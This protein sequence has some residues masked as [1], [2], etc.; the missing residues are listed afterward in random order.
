MD[1][2]IAGVPELTS[3]A[4]VRGEQAFQIA[5]ESFTNDKLVTLGKR[6]SALLKDPEVNGVVVTHGTDTLEETAFFLHLC[7]PAAIP[8]VLTG[9]FNTTPDSAAWRTLGEALTDARAAAPVH[10]GPE[11]TFHGFTGTPDRRIDAVF[12]DPDGGWTVID[13]KTGV[14]PEPARRESLFIQLAA[15]RI[16]WAQLAGVPV[17][18]VRAAFH[19]VRSGH[20]LAADELPDE[21]ALAAK[22]ARAP[23]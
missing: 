11:A 15:Y 8:V 21:S 6:V 13:W 19:Y 9:D 20:T 18:R 12:A 7:L 17:D 2:L 16:A 5:S 4:N 23:Q 14:V 22:L 3:V 1:K 10:E